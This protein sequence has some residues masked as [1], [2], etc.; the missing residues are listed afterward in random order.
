M[1]VT[2]MSVKVLCKV[3]SLIS[4]ME[5]G[6]IAQQTPSE[7]WGGPWRP[8]RSDTAFCGVL[9][10]QIG[11]CQVLP[12]PGAKELS[13]SNLALFFSLV[14]HSQVLSHV[15]IVQPCRGVRMQHVVADADMP[16]GSAS[17]FLSVVQKA[18]VSSAAR[19]ACRLCPRGA[20]RTLASEGF[21]IGPGGFSGSWA[22]WEVKTSCGRTHAVVWLGPT[23]A[24][25]RAAMFALQNV[26]ADGDQTADAESPQGAGAEEDHPQRY[27]Q[28]AKGTT[29][30]VTFLSV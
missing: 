14:A 30:L 27:H 7:S 23:R 21:C 1:A 16:E 17:V 10:H 12:W 13:V 24:K 11:S 6:S 18:S 20:G 9:Q 8:Y 22:L 29:S 15:D 3:G 19:K 25:L 26:L 28:R 5:E 2:C 4:T